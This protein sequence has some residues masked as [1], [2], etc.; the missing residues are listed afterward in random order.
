MAMLLFGDDYTRGEVLANLS[1]EQKKLGS[2]SSEELPDH[3]SNILRLIARM[4]D[5]QTLNDFGKAYGC[6]CS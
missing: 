5:K 6:S 1:A 4:E 2:F 3:L